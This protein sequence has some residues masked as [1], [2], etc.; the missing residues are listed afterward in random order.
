MWSFDRGSLP[1]PPEER[2]SLSSKAR[3]IKLSPSQ[4]GFEIA[5]A[6]ANA[7]ANASS[8]NASTS[9]N[10]ANEDVSDISVVGIVAERSP[11]KSPR[12][13]PVAPRIKPVAPRI[14]LVAPGNASAEVAEESLASGGAGGVA[15]V[16]ASATVSAHG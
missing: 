4:K 11:L 2:E 1:G 13:K 6:S 3:G 14:K 5:S 16:S 12:S 8:A 15:N 10:A 9:A 7:N